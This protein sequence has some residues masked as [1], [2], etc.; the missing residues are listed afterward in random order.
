MSHVAEQLIDSGCAYLCAWGPGCERVHD[1]FDEI[2]VRMD[3]DPADDSVV[4][5]TWHADESIEEALWV[6]LRG[7]SPDE[8][9]E[10]S[11]RSGVVVVVGRADDHAAVVRHA[12]AQPRDFA[13]KVEGAGSAKGRRRR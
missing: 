6:F 11:C 12:L 7:T 1:I 10:D 9:H 8:R 4:M 5:T 3:P 2:L 13:R